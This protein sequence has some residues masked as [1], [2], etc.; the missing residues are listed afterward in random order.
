MTIDEI[1][2]EE[3]DTQNKVFMADLVKSVQRAVQE[4][5][6]FP[7]VKITKKMALEIIEALDPHSFILHTIKKRKAEHQPTEIDGI[8]LT[9]PKV[10]RY[11]FVKRKEPKMVWSFKDSKRIPNPNF[12]ES[13]NAGY[14]P[15]YSCLKTHRFEATRKLP[16]LSP[17]EEEGE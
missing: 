15:A 14:R 16:P 11:S 6:L 5:G 8:S 17:Q 10:G 13:G 7:D 1:V 12:E 3:G 4:S 2:E 9:L